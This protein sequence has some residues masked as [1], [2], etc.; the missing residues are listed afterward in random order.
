MID[1]R[2]LTDVYAAKFAKIL[3]VSIFAGHVVVELWSY[4]NWFK[5]DETLQLL[6]VF[7]LLIF[8][9]A[10]ICHHQTTTQ[11]EKNTMRTI[12]GL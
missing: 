9:C 12:R 4:Q 7:S 1:K 8:K 10:N 11:H 2:V 3:R 5:G 6:I